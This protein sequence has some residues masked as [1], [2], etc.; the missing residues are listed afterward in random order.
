[1]NE[2]R[3]W[4][5]AMSFLARHAR[6]F[7]SERNLRRGMIAVAL[8][9]LALGVVAQ[10]L[11]QLPLA[12]LIW[13]AA[14]LPVIAG[15]A[16]SIVRDLAAGRFGVDAVAFVSMTAALALG[17][18]LAGVVVAVMYAGGNVLEDFAVARA[19]RDLKSL[20]DRAPRIA[21]RRAAGRVED[22][23]DRAGGDRRPPR[24]ARRRGRSGRRHDRQPRGD[25]RRIGADGR[26]DPGRP[27]RAASR[28]AAARSMPARPSRWRRRDGRREHLCRHRAHGDGGADREGAVHPAGRSLCAAAAA[29]HAVGRRR[30]LAALRRSD[31]RARRAGRGDALSADPRGTGRL[32]RRRLAGRAPRHPDQGRR[33][34]RGA[35]AHAHG[36]VRQDRNADGRRRAPGRGRDGARRE[37]GRGAAAGRL[38][39][40]GLASC[41]RR[42]HRGR[43]AGEGPRL[44]MPSS[45]RETH[46]LRARRRR[47][48]PARCRVGSHQLVAR[49]PAGRAIGR[50]ARCGAPPGDR[51]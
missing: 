2:S 3:D 28:R 19:E 1:M 13:T 5:G 17:Q 24:R 42:G 18:P 15:L 50:C 25:D 12:R 27:R 31:P 48:R 20:V 7:A 10:L 9:G 33:A 14:T 44:A 26:A 8:A 35:G 23:T 47:R 34:A 45:V 37:R 4:L 43:G 11:S 40:A 49:R 36:D 32:H 41:R 38:A 6:Q 51:R 29:G 16:I 30:R 46:G 39:G 21:H 22:V